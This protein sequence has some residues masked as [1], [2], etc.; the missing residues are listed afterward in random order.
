MLLQH[1][2]QVCLGRSRVKF[3][4]AFT[5]CCLPHFQVLTVVY[6]GAWLFVYY[7]YSSRKCG[8]VAASTQFSSCAWWPFL[9]SVLLAGLHMS[10]YESVSKANEAALLDMETNPPGPGTSEHPTTPGGGP[11][12][13]ALLQSISQKVDRIDE[14]SKANEKPLKRTAQVSN[15]N[16]PTDTIKRA[17]SAP[18]D[19]SNSEQ[20]DDDDMTLMAFFLMPNPLLPGTVSP[21]TGYT[22]LQRREEMRT[23]ALLSQELAAMVEKRFKQLHPAQCIKELCKTYPLPVNCGDVCVPKVNGKVRHRLDQRANRPMKFRDTCLSSV[24]HSIVGGVGAII[25]MLEAFTQA[26]KGGAALLDPKALFK[27]G[28]NALSMLG[29]ANYEASLRRRESLKGIVKS[30]LAPDLCGQDIPVTKLLLV[31]VGHDVGCKEHTWSKNG[32]KSHQGWKSR[33]TWQPKGPYTKNKGKPPK[34]LA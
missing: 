3:E 17:H 33:K 34:P 26:S 7:S 22:N 23:V 4:T 10:H 32:W 27:M 9:S 19:I 13:L 21:V 8:A 29:H 20:D 25:Q 30:E 15:N 6:Q 16:C 11:S 12:I 31:H 14:R 1:S 5:W 18:D 24:Q 2:F 28:L